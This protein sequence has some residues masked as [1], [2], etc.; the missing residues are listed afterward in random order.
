MV[1]NAVQ[2]IVF[3][4]VSLFVYTKLAGPISFSINNVN[5]QNNTPFQTTGTGEVKA[6]PDKTSVSLGITTNAATADAARSQANAVINKVTADLK[7]IGISENDIKTS[8]FSIYP[9]NPVEPQVMGSSAG[10]SAIVPR[11]S[12][13]QGYTA[14]ANLEV[15]TS[16]VDLANQA[17]DKAS[18]DGANVIGGV[19]FTFNDTQKQKLEDEARRKAVA[20]AKQKAQDLASAA[21]IKL[22]RIINIQESDNGFP[23]PMMTAKEGSVPSDSTNLQPGQNKVTITVTLTFETQ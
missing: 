9:N 23:V 4:F 19:N 21:G 11:P 13:A 10:T 17:I 18:S 2:I 5:T 14:S 15:Q 20:D 8:N 22:G 3:F 1:K 12:A 6:T 7:S 16:S